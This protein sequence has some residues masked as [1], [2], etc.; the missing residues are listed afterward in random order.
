VSIAQALIFLIKTKLKMYGFA[1]IAPQTLFGAMRTLNVTAVLIFTGQTVSIV[2]RTLALNANP[3]F[4]L[5]TEK[6]LASLTLRFA[7][8]QQIK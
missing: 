7:S 6:N 1:I 2:I 5:L 8:S 4:I 3:I